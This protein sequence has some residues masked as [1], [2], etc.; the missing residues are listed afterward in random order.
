M[1]EYFRNPDIFYS[2]V[3]FLSPLLYLIYLHR[4][5][6]TYSVHVIKNLYSGMGVFSF[7]F[8]LVLS[9]LLWI[10]TNDAYSYLVKK[11][12][13][14]SG[15]LTGDLMLATAHSIAYIVA[16]KLLIEES[17]RKYKARK[18]QLK[19]K[20]LFVIKLQQGK[21]AL[22]S[23]N[24]YIKNNKD[25]FL[26]SFEFLN[27][28]KYGDEKRFKTKNYLGKAIIFSSENGSVIGD[29]FF[30][31]KYFSGVGLGISFSD[32]YALEEI[33]CYF[34]VEFLRDIHFYLSYGCVNNI[35]LNDDYE[36]FVIIGNDNLFKERQSYYVHHIFMNN[37]KL[38]D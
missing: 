12:G 30:G 27:E 23:F 13:D 7:L 28:I 19:K 6:D 1:S 15:F 2:L 25:F 10:T 29:S 11:D 3:I 4:I 20:R 9:L 21:Y 32:N 37:F 33:D 22:L 26:K 35:Y 17:L 34:S 5:N 38:F 14:K 16:L 18:N 36:D 24:E 8:F 31:I